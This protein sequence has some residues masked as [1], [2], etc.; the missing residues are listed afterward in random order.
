MILWHDGAHG[1]RENMRRDAALLEAAISGRQS[2]PILRL[3]RFAPRGITLGRSQEPARELD[4]TRLE[5]SGLEWA[6]RPTG[7]RAIFHDEEWTFSLTTALGGD[8]WASDAS[9]A[10][11]RTCELLAN[12]LRSLGVPVEESAG[13]IRGVGSPRERSGPAAPCFASTARHELTIAGRKVAG[14]A[15]RQVRNVLLQQGSI[16]LGDSHLELV[17]W[18]P[19]PPTDRSDARARLAEGSTHPGPWLA[20]RPDL[21]RLAQACATVLPRAGNVGGE[22]GARELGLA[23]AD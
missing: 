13:S 18:I 10:Y 6:R 9:A 19:I 11:A 14:I 8:G 21:A 20:S 16:L 22:D 1:P 7:G 17:E 23:N 2:M 15:Q 12:A 3:F 4:L 5:P